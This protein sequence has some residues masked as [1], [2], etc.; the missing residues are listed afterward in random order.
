[1]AEEK[2]KEEQYNFLINDVFPHYIELMDII[3]SNDPEHVRRENLSKFMDDCFRARMLRVPIDVST[4][5]ISEETE[6][7]IQ[8][9]IS[10]LKW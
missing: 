7:R 2:E 10:N 5:L 6:E 8:R 3:T 1:M 9:I 4:R